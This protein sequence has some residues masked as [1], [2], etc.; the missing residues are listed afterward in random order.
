MSNDERVYES[1]KAALGR[2]PDEYD[3]AIFGYV[4][5]DGLETLPGMEHTG[6]RIL[7]CCGQ[8]TLVY[9]WKREMKL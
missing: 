6:W 1:A 3:M 8:E 9:L 4:E 2:D 7:H 5:R